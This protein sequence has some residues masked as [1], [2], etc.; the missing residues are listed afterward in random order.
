MPSPPTPQELWETTL[1]RLRLQMSQATFDT[2]LRDTRLAGLEAGQTF[3]IRVKSSAAQAWLEH[4]LAPLI[5]Q[6]LAG[7]V[8]GPVNLKFVVA[9]P[10]QPAL[11]ATNTP[12]ATTT[13][14]PPPTNYPQPA[15]PD[16]PLPPAAMLDF[17]QLWL[18]SGFTQLPDYVIHYWRIHLGRAFDLWE[19]L[20]SQ[21]K[22]NVKLMAQ[23][24]LPYW[25]EPRRYTYRGLAGLLNCG[26]RAL[27]GR[28]AP[29]SLYERRKDEARQQ[30]HDPATLAC[31]GKYQP[32]A[33]RL[34]S[35]GEPACLHWL[36]GF[37]ERLDREGLI[38]V[39]RLAC[40]GKP[41]AH[42]LYLQAWRLIPLLTPAQVARFKRE[43]ERER[44]RTWLERYGHLIQLDLAGWEQITLPSLLPHL[45]GY[46]WGRRFDQPYTNNPLLPASPIEQTLV[47]PTPP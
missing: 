24:K 38:T 41:R 2:W 44:H 11:A 1:A 20:A 42:E 16:D 17:E 22:R 13:Y 8:G 14:Q 47:C 34:N 5:R 15:P 27:T 46:A 40:P 4:R 18:K 25:T 28:L 30:D 23:R 32:C 43:A 35:R 19:Y 39:R 33:I 29:C 21:D 3:L 26:R 37:L 12:Q 36:E 45:P 31:C 6:T 7:V 9:P 10:S